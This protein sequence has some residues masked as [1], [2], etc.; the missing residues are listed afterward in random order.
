MSEK[1]RVYFDCMRHGQKEKDQLTGFG[2]HQVEASTEANL[3]GRRYLMAFY[4][5]ATRTKQT[6]ETA[7][8]ALAG[9]GTLTP[10]AEEGFGSAWALDPRWPFES[11][12]QAVKAHRYGDGSLPVDLW[13]Q[14]WP[15]ALA[16][17][18]RFLGTLER[19]TLYAAMRAAE[20]GSPVGDGVRFLVAS[21][22][23]TAELACLDPSTTPCL[24]L[25]DGITYCLEVSL[26]TLEMEL[27][28]SE[29]WR[30][31]EHVE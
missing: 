30:C 12:D 8:S 5:G 20:G 22:S 21:H 26:N 15:V 18:G 1:I 3:A 28:S 13:L 9:N 23:P 11:A 2:V 7:L 16:I 25:A 6:V 10:R 24:G 14:F 19:W 31:P 4:S 17:R 27:I 29:V